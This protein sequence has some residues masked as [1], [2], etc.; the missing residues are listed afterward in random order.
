MLNMSACLA[1]GFVLFRKFHAQLVGFLTGHV[2]ELLE[3]ACMHSLL[4]FLSIK[5]ELVSI[6]FHTGQVRQ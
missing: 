1:C 6:G 4:H 2:H 5:D 3:G